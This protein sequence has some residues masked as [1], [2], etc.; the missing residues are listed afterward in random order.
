MMKCEKKSS[1]FAKYSNYGWDKKQRRGSVQLRVEEM[2]KK[3]KQMKPGH[4]IFE[5]V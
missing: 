5:W 1:S 4:F 2:D 3:Q